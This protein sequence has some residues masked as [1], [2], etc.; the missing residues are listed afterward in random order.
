MLNQIRFQIMNN[1]GENIKS[2]FG[3]MSFI[4]LMVQMFAIA[5]TFMICFVF[6]LFIK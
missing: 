1:K 6:Y 3:K 5:M 2:L 4:Y